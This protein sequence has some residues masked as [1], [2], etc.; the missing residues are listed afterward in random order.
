MIHEIRVLCPER[1][2]GTRTIARHLMRAGIQISR[3]S[4]KRILEGDPPEKFG[5]ATPAAERPGRPTS[6]ILYARPS[7]TSSGTG[8]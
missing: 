5:A 8:T 3:T 6:A 1:D 4:V 2:F 7:P